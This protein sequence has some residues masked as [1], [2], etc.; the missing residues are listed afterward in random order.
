MSLNKNFFI[1]KVTL[2]FVFILISNYD[3]HSYQDQII[4]YINN[5]I[6][7]LSA[8][9][10][11]ITLIESLNGIKIKQNQKFIIINSLVDEKLLSQIADI[12]HIS[13]TEKKVN[14]YLQNVA[15][16]N[17]LNNLDKL[18]KE[19]KVN[20][21]ELIQYVKYQLLIKNFIEYKIKPEILVSNQEVRDNIS[22]ISKIVY[23]SLLIKPDTELQLYEI[24]FCKEKVPRERI[25]NKLHTIYSSLNK[26]I[27]FQDLA[28]QFSES[29]TSCNNGLLGWI[30]VNHLSANII[31]VLGSNLDIG[32]I[33]KPID[34]D[35]RVMIINIS[36]VKKV[37]YQEKQLRQ[38]ELKNI[39]YHQKLKA[40]FIY[41]ITNLRKNSYIKI[42]IFNSK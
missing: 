14:D 26:G 9:Q 25:K 37:D 11:R 15:V 23:K 33:S 7:T 5:D 31:S 8:V 17:G 29:T 12:N 16:H 28:R 19:Y 2:L 39:I 6:I 27:L 32:M 34:I 40:N 35:N 21:S 38:Q 10:N 13:I 22:I 4:G 41:Y 42:A 1:V 3:V 30:K 36:N 24:V 20:K 18:V